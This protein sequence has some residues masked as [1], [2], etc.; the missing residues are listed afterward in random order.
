MT[1]FQP[2]DVVRLTGDNWSNLAGTEQTIA[3][4]SVWDTPYFRFGTGALLV[5]SEEPRGD[6]GATLVFRATSPQAVLDAILDSACPASDP[7]PEDWCAYVDEWCGERAEVSA[8]AEET[9]RAILARHPAPTVSDGEREGMAAVIARANDL[10][11]EIV[12]GGPAQDRD[13]E[14]TDA[15][16]AAG[17]RKP[18]LPSVDIDAAWEAHLPVVAPYHVEPLAK[19][20]ANAVARG[21]AY[22]KGFRAGATAIKAHLLDGGNRG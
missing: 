17:Y 8:D 19:Y 16:L 4:V 3:G 9:F 11:L 10:Y 6:R 22:E 20:D 12:P 18:T 13:Y 15:L 14:I 21:V 1:T 2:G 7:D 5:N